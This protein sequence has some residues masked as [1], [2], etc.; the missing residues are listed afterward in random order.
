MQRI[1]NVNVKTEFGANS[2]L[3]AGVL[4]S[5]ERERTILMHCSLARLEAD[6]EYARMKE[7]V[8]L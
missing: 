5:A 1:G 3:P 8:Q 4:R 6:R 7:I 2:R